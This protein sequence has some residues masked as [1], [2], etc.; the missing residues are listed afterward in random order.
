MIQ[1]TT[2][3]SNT[4]EQ[5]RSSL[6]DQRPS[7]ATLDAIRATLLPYRCPRKTVRFSNFLETKHEIPIVPDEYFVDVF[8]NEFEIQDARNKQVV[9]MRAA[10]AERRAAREK[11]D[12]YFEIEN[13][14]ITWRGLED[15]RDGTKK[16]A[17]ASCHQ[18][19]VM[20]EWRFQLQEGIRDFEELRKVSKYS[21]R[22]SVKEARELGRADAKAAGVVKPTMARKASDTMLSLSRNLSNNSITRNLSNASFRKV[23]SNPSLSVKR[24]NTN[25]SN[26]RAPRKVSNASFRKAFGMP[27]STAAA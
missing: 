11:G 9:E 4:L 25:S 20:E 27:T 18:I 1:R 2:S 15:M 8:Y 21:S 7:N 16:S 10:L 23:A 17:R 26:G 3:S 5:K 12:L 22:K 24:T 13:D 6:K 19:E 14:E